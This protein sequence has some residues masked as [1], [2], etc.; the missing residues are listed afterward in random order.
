MSLYG[1]LRTGVSGL[2]ANSQR[3]A[4]ISDNIANLNTV[5]YKR[6]EAEFS[7]FLTVNSSASYNSGGIQSQ[8]TRDISQQGSIEI[9]NSS[10]DL[11]ISGTGYFIVTD[12]LNY[13][14]E[15]D[16]YSP[17]G[18][19]F[20]TRSGNFE[21]D[22]TGN[23]RNSDGY[24]LLS[25]PRNDADTD[26]VQNG[27]S[28]TLVPVG[29]SNK[30]Y[31]PV[32]TSEI[33]MGINLTTTTGTGEDNVYRVRQSI[34][35]GQGTPRN[36]E[37]IYERVAETGPEQ[38]MHFLDENG[39]ALS[40]P[41]TVS[42]PDH[43]RVYAQ[44]ENAA[45]G[46]YGS[47]GL[48]DGIDV[49]TTEPI[50][51]ADLLFDSSGGLD[52]ML[53]PGLITEYQKSKYPLQYTDSFNRGVTEAGSVSSRAID[54]RNNL[55]RA[56]R[57]IMGEV[58]DKYTSGLTFSSTPT[59]PEIAAGIRALDTTAN[60]DAMLELYQAMSGQA[61]V[62][63]GGRTANGKPPIA[64]SSI[65]NYTTYGVEFGVPTFGETTGSFV[66]GRMVSRDGA[67][68]I[69]DTTGLAKFADD[70]NEKI[71]ISVDYVGD[72]N[73]QTNRGTIDIDI[74]SF[75]MNSLRAGGV[76]NGTAA[77]IAVTNAGT[78]GDGTTNFYDQV[79]TVRFLENNGKQ[80]SSLQ[81]INFNSNG[82][83]MGN[84]S[85]GEARA[86]YK[87]PLAT[88]ANPNGMIARSGNAYLQ[89]EASGIPTIAEA[90]TGTTGSIR[91]SSLESSS[92]DVAQ[93]FSDMIITQRGYSAATKV[94]S[95]ADQ[96]LQ[97][98]A[99]LR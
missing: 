58:L 74:G 22:P 36:L 23:L 83:V 32:P 99:A 47:N 46:N 43:W 49:T 67:V 19:V 14:A 41:Y 29:T 86:L 21:E 8:A 51:I 96:M 66:G 73:N 18:R 17:S 78:G 91:G 55:S 87:V 9:S 6:A 24:Y 79:S 12:A 10:T 3:I 72:F 53:P 35:D 1:S 82:E 90:D 60:P 69:D 84:Y 5:G 52:T 65:A 15:A 28:S 98:L 64:N 7:T 4:M 54:L 42:Q 45:I 77:D 89:S 40:V 44:V 95:A 31:E 57:I 97:E 2:N 13:D 70:G 20:Y 56:D 11:A 88:F 75:S 48:L 37:L 62:N 26:Y 63:D 71:R 34:I 93:E 30:N 68:Q 80:F 81:Y 76:L 94:I 33:E 16:T 25:W 85:N 38:E 59:T 27:E 50:A 61:F 92:V 39:D